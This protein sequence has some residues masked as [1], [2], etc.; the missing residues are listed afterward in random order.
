MK[1][2]N[3]SRI[4]KARIALLMAKPSSFGVYSSFANTRS[5]HL[6]NDIT[7]IMKTISLRHSDQSLPVY[8]NHRYYHQLG[9]FKRKPLSVSPNVIKILYRITHNDFKFA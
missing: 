7:V 8:L 5:S 3:S 4:E 9:P 2:I 1:E 6:D